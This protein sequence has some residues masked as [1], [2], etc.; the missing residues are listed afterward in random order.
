MTMDTIGA[1]VDASVT[2]PFHDEYRRRTHFSG[3]DGLRFA[4]I[5]AVIWHHSPVI[6][7]MVDPPLLLRRGFLGVDFFFVLSGFL[8]TTLLVRERASTGRVSLRAF[9]WRRLLRIVPVSYALIAAV[10]IFL[11]VVEG[12]TQWAA[13]V[14]FSVLFLANFLTESIPF[15]SPL[16]SL[17]VEEQYYLVW[18]LVLIVTPRR[19]VLPL[20]AALVALNVWLAT[21][22]FVHDGTRGIDA[23]RL[24]LSL[25][26]ATYA[27]ILLGSALA[28]VLHDRRG[29]TLAHRWLSGRWAAPIALSTVVALAAALPGDLIGLPNL[30]IHLTMTA[31]LAALVLNEDNLLAPVLRSRPV[32]RI[33]VV[34]YGLYLYHLI[35]LD[36]ANRSLA[37][38]G[39]DRAWAVLVLYPIISYAIAE[40]SYR[41]LESY[42]RSLRARRG[43]A[44]GTTTGRPATTA[45]GL[46]VGRP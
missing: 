19:V 8:I 40:T 36:F 9:Y 6:H 16:W 23:G 38:V 41:T 32:V 7:E 45:V 21:T 37:A 5:A 20:L 3:L 43:T 15:L 1:G 18:P 24:Q 30:A 17:A 44:F 31:A 34:S 29:F 28:L 13:L 35:G 42:F 22:G 12:E 14:P 27:P 46:A 2:D 25:P 39:F 11:I 4:C 26:N 10:S 33:G